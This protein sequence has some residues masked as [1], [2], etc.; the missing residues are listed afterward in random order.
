MDVFSIN[1]ES[2]APKYK[3]IVGSIEDAIHNG[4]LKKGDKLP[5]LN[6]IKIKHHLSSFSEEKKEAL[7]LTI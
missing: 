1:I 5:S 7:H 2:G 6:S 4:I 3:Q